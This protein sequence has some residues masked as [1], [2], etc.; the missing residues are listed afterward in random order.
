MML[1]IPHCNHRKNHSHGKVLQRV[2]SRGLMLQHLAQHMIHSS[3]LLRIIKSKSS[4]DGFGSRKYNCA[5]QSH[6]QSSIARHEDNAVALRSSLRVLQTRQRVPPAGFPTLAPR[7][8]DPLPHCNW[9]WSR[10][11]IHTIRSHSK[12]RKN[13][14]TRSTTPANPASH[15]T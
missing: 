9:R 11:Y 1:N 15:E 10:V 13:F 8:N 12:E 6:L 2:P 5:Y 3:N 14:P 4:D 7:P